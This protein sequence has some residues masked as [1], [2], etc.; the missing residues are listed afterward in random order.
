LTALANAGLLETNDPRY[1]PLTKQTMYDSS[2]TMTNSARADGGKAA[3]ER[4][5]KL[6]TFIEG[7][8]AIRDDPRRKSAFLLGALIG[9][10]S[11]YQESR[12][13]RATTLVDQFPIKGLTVQKFKRTLYEALD[14]DMVYARDNRMSG[15][16]YA[17]VVDELRGAV[18]ASESDPEE[19]EI[20][21]TDLRFY[22]SLGVTYGLN[23]YEPNEDN[24]DEEA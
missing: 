21:T 18:A 6:E 22:Y 13:N 1:E 17:E 15:T 9:H 14:K 7:T 11:G 20:D 19:W 10:V 16:M 8:P 12:E 2:P 23:D 5:A 24:P 4:E 3:V